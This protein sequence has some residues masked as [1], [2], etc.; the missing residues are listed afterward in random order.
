MHTSSAPGAAFLLG[1]HAVV[2]GE[3]ALLCAVERRATASVELIERERDLIKAENLDLSGFTASYSHGETDL[4]GDAGESLSYVTT[5]LDAARNYLDSEQRFRV[6]VS[7]DIP[8]G[9]GLGSS[10]AVTVATLHAVFNAVSYK[11][12]R[13]ELADLSN[14]VEVE[15]Q[16]GNASPSDTYT[17]TMGGV[18]YIEPGSGVNEI[19]AEEIELSIGYDGGDA[20]T[21]EM[22]A[23]VDRRRKNVPEVQSTIETIGDLVDRGLDAVRSGDIEELGTAMNI[24]QGLLEAI[25]VGGGSL[26]RMTWAARDAGAVGSKLTGA[27][28][29]G[30]VVAVPDSPE[31]RSCMSLEGEYAFS[32]CQAEGVR[33]E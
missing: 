17:S 23:M 21:G 8:I 11:I 14:G 32:S 15:V 26:A 9:G 5:A 28:G 18:T 10:A 22:V 24:N 33:S 16:G 6:E 1:E 29:E 4:T 27:G 2:Y 13:E 12:E 31:I 3:P 7:S 25:G 19:D 30:C 20:P